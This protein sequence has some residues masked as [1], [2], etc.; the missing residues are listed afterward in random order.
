[1]R[2]EVPQFIEIEDKVVGPLTWKQF[3][4]VAGGA[5]GCLA[6]W[7]SFPR[8]VALPLIALVGTLALSLAFFR[9]NKRPFINLMESWFYYTLGSKL[10]IWKKRPAKA[11]EPTL[12]EEAEAIINPQVYVPKMSDSK[13]KDLS[14][15]LDID[16]RNSGEVL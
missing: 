13:L 15:A 11:T 3:L 5:G 16:H 8:F 10:Y 1:M 12:E 2:Y 9:Y 4:Y 7:L 6:M 14:W